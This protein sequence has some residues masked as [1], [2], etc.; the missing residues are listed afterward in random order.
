MKKGF[1]FYAAATFFVFCI[2][3]AGF[4][5]YQLMIGKWSNTQ[6]Y[7]GDWSSEQKW[8]IHFFAACYLL[9][10][11]GIYFNVLNPKPYR[12]ETH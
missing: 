1:K 9:V 4:F 10:A 2:F 8:I 6:G 3:A 5:Y 11:A 7:L 12:N